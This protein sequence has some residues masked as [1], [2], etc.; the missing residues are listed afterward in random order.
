MG[1]VPLGGVG[2]GEVVVGK[3]AEARAREM[4]IT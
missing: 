3:G 2:I 4:G 1:E